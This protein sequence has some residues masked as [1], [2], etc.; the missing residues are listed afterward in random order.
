MDVFASL[1]ELEGGVV[2]A[3]VGLD[4]AHHHRLDVRIINDAG[5]DLCSHRY[6]LIFFTNLNNEVVVKNRHTE[7]LK[8]TRVQS[9]GVK[10]KVELHY[11]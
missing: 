10:F 2:D 6:S 9:M 11:S 7:F 3:G 1:H 5:F 4:S 8:E